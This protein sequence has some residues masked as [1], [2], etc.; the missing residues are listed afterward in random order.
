MKKTSAMLIGFLFIGILISCDKK[1]IKPSS[2]I[3]VETRE[4]ASF[5]SIDVSDALDVEVTF[6]AGPE[7]VVVEANSNLQAYLITEVN[8]GKLEIHWKK[9]TSVMPGATVKI[10]VSATEVNAM[11]ASGASNIQLMN[12]WTTST[13][14]VGLSGASSMRGNIVAESATMNL[15]G[16]SNADFTGAL[17]SLNSECSGASDLRGFGLSVDNLVLNLSGASTT[18][19]TVNSTI[20]LDA[21][22]AS[23][24]SYKGNASISSLNLTGSSTIH[25]F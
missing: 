5:S 3:T 10:R 16:A 8:N 20:N 9:G 4:V 14:A 15:S 7:Q 21:S 11:E 25:K 2:D 17:L 18:E 13:A 22:G 23:D 1:L 24:F 6:V 12:A 19:L